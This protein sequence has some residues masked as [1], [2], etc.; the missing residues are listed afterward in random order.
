VNTA[1]VARFVTDAVVRRPGLWRLLRGRT[2]DMFDDIAPTWETRIGPDHVAALSLALAELA[3]PARALDLGTGTGVAA[4]AVARRFESAHVVGVDLA[5]AM[6]AQAEAKLPPELAARVGFQVG[7]ASE[8]P[9]DDG[10]FELVTL[11]NMIPFFDEL[12]RVTA[13]AGAIVFS[14]SRG[15]ETPIYVRPERL[16]REL[17]RRGFALF[18]DF[19]AGPSTA[20][21]ARRR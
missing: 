6:V 21:L 16:R 13:P 11:A 14:F 5:P 17:G 10:A 19:S 20:L 2:R 4:Q 1:R 8:L 7:D 3:P 15:A 12:A 9:F 18:A